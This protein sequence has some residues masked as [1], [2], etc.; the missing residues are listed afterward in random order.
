MKKMTMMTAAMLLS[1]IL[2]FAATGCTADDSVQNNA[3]DHTTAGVSETVDSEAETETADASD[4]AEATETGSSVSTTSGESTVAS[5]VSYTGSM[6]NVLDVSSVFTERDLTQTADLT[7]AQYLSVSNGQML[8]VTEAGVFVISGTAEECTI[9]VDTDS[10]EKVQLVLD[11]VS[12][13]NSDFP[14]IYVKSADKVFITTTDSTNT[15]SVTGSFTSDGENNTDAV[16]YSTDDLVLNGVGSL[17]I[18]SAYGNGIS[19]KDDLKVTG[20]TYTI[21]AAEDALEANDSIAICGGSFTIKAGKDGF[22]CENDEA[23]GYIYIAD[24]TLSISASDDGIQATTVLRI[25]GGTVTISGSEGMEATYV[26]INGGTLDITALDDGINAA[27]KSYS[28]DAAI[29]VNGGDISVTMGSGDVDGFDANGSI[30][31]NGGTVSI[32]VSEVGTAEAFDFDGSAELNGGTVY[33]NGEQITEITTGMM[34]GGMMGGFGGQGGGFSD[35]MGRGGFGG[36]N[37]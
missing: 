3:A 13:T 32:S 14:A 27:Q 17:T 19:A 11:G 9:I 31:I 25:D 1:V 10:T 23:E 7:D 36:R 26:Q 12:I 6:E 22:H 18:T 35:G 2:A 15:L 4:A 16:I 34:G 33:V 5:V 8:T 30:Y 29:E 20:G 37:M 24:G 21:T 28:V